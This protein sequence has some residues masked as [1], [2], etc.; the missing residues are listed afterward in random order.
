MGIGSVSRHARVVLVEAVTAGLWER[1]GLMGSA[2]AEVN[3]PRAFGESV[4]KTILRRDAQ[5][6]RRRLQY[7]KTVRIRMP[8]GTNRCQ[9]YSCHNA[10][11]NLPSRHT[12][13]YPRIILK[14]RHS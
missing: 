2:T 12:E 6:V 3:L 10:R 4:P 5:G 1:D 7:P 9:G 14:S 13:Y 11:Q 8:Y